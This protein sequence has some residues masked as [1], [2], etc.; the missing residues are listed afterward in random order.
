[1]TLE[2]RTRGMLLGAFVGD[3]LALGPHWM[4]DRSK[5]EQK[6]GRISGLNDPATQYHPGKKAGDYTHLGD[7]MLVLQ[8]S[9]QIHGGLFDPKDFLQSW[10]A[11]WTD[12]AT[13]SYVDKATRTVLGAMEDGFAAKEVA[14]SSTEFAGPV[15]GIPVLVTGL[16]N[17]YDE[18]SLITAMK[19]QTRLTHRSTEAQDVAAFLA[20]LGSGLAAE[21]DLETALDGALGD[22]SQFVRDSGRKAEAPRLANVTTGEAV[23][24]LGQTCDSDEALPSSIYILRR[25]QGSFEE[26]LI[27]NVMAGGDSAAR[28]IFIGAVLG[29]LH[30]EQGIPEAWRN[31]L[32]QVAW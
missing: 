20:R 17:G 26:A 6:F 32:R 30:G 3:A 14:S 18:A 29:W 31:G 11:F 2:Q 7:Q 15:R 8:R 21:L 12:P 24:S 4:Y 5:I 27:E 16:A 22:S 28:G 25:H 13:K 23:E 10:K 1:M 9:I 19:E